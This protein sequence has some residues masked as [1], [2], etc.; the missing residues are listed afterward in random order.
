V[1][2]KNIK[3]FNILLK[4][5]KILLVGYGK[6]GS[7]LARGWL[8]KKLKIEI[9]VIE[10]EK[11]LSSKKNNIIFYNS[12]ED[13]F[14]AKKSPDIILIAIKPQQ[15]KD[16]IVY[17]NKIYKK[18]I[19]FISVVAGISTAWFK[20]KISKE[21]KIVRAMPNL[22]SSVLSGVTGIYN[23]TNILKKEIE[24]IKIIL[25]SIGE[26][27]LLKNEKL[28]D[29]VTS[30]SG[31]GPAYYFYLTE[32]LTEVGVKLG[33]KKNEAE[34]LA[35]QTFVGSA[36]LL[37]ETKQNFSKLRK[38]VTSPGGT[39]EAA[40]SILMNDRNGL[41]KIFTKALSAALTRAKELGNS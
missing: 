11:V 9:S 40:L 18:N 13:Y 8:K 22:P 4:M 41:N 14:E 27:I 20:E 29:I 21:I 3:T 35:Y 19:I 7:S 5:T 6:M 37:K 1:L 32:V 2:N 24:N 28:I 31:S 39:T 33:L 10:K 30:I 26:I 16:I 25:K 17:L 34:I 38:D 36:K 23:S 15:L 12:F